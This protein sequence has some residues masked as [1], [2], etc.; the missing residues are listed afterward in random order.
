[1]RAIRIVDYDPHWI[2]LF[3]A[4]RADLLALLCDIVDDIHHV[5]STS[6]PG[7]PAK[8][9]IDIDAV[10]TRAELVAEAV[11]RLQSTAR[12]RFHGAPHGDDRWV[13]TSGHGSYGIRLY[14]CGPNNEMHAKRIMFRDWLLAHPDDA[15]EY[16]GLK[17]Q[18][19]S[20]ANGD[21]DIY[22]GGK[23]DFV[24]R[25]VRQASIFGR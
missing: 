23:A 3:E 13:F 8:P 19:A 12:Y 5:G 16:A 9:K 7:L 24:A 15:A 4:E 21:W 2:R 1:M 18:L 11:M 14:L 17:R 6:V 10:A 20:Q 25:I 22:T